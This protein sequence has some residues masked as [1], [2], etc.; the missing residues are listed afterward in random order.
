[1][2]RNFR[3]RSRTLFPGEPLT[4]PL[5]GRAGTSFA[6]YIHIREMLARRLGL[7][8]NGAFA[9]NPTTAGLLDPAPVADDFTIKD[10][11]FTM[12][13]ES[14]ETLFGQLGYAP[15]QV[16][17]YNEKNRVVETLQV[18]VREQMDSTNYTSRIIG[19]KNDLAVYKLQ[20][21]AAI[22]TSGIASVK[23]PDE[24]EEVYIRAPDLQRMI[25]TIERRIAQL[26]ALESGGLFLGGVIG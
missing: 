17:D 5:S 9:L 16:L 18:Y 6:L 8:E 1:M 11:V 12:T 10:D 2:P 20:L 22:S 24:H 25:W 13:S 14:I 21:A 4:L 7:Y 3:R 26:E 15:L 23:L 19:L